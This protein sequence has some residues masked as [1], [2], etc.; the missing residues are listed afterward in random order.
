MGYLP[1]VYT[2]STLVATPFSRILGSG[3]WQDFLYQS[4]VRNKRIDSYQWPEACYIY[5]AINIY[6]SHNDNEST[7]ESIVLLFNI[8]LLNL[9]MS[10]IPTFLSERTVYF[11]LILIFH[12]GSISPIL[13]LWTGHQNQVD[14]KNQSA[15]RKHS[16]SIIHWKAKWEQDVV[17][18]DRSPFDSYPTM[19]IPDSFLFI[20]NLNPPLSFFNFIEI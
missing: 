2:S 10:P 5:N 16:G 6:Y 15:Q 13:T 18:R 19:S 7:W 4:Q 11:L 17:I 3:M 9:L 1:R 8:H 20:I 12:L 14:D